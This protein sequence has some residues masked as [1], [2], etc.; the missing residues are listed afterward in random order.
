MDINHAQ[1]IRQAQNIERIRRS[2]PYGPTQS[3]E[4]SGGKSFQEILGDHITGKENEIKFSAHAQNRIQQRNIPFGPE[5]LTPLS[6]AITKAA[7]KGSQESLVLMDNRA[8]VVSV[9]N[10]TVITA[11]DREQMQDNVFTNIDSTVWM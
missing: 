10:R 4:P 11:V 8:F 9:P 3:V 5:D 6:H 1:V 2:T 7:E